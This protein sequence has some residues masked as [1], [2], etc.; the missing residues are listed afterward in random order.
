MNNMTSKSTP[1]LIAALVIAAFLV[2]TLWTKVQYLEK[3]PA[4]SAS[5]SPEANPT[6]PDQTPAAKPQINIRPEDPTKGSK[7]AKLTIT[8]FSDPSCPFCA[9]AAG[10]SATVD[11]LK[12]NDP[13]WT[14]PVPGIIKEYVNTGKV[15]L[16]FKYY[17]GHGTGEEAMKYL[18]CA[19]DQ[20]KFWELHDEEF[21][22]QEKLDKASLDGYVKKLGLDSA[23]IA[24]CLS[25][26]KYDGFAAK[27]TEDGKL[28]QVSGTPGFFIGDKS[29]PGAYS[30]ATLKVAIE[31]ELKK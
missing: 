24:E 21:A 28:A 8:V 29:F 30:F 12:K 17:P 4:P 16:V 11:Y 14:A 26:G 22:N 31:E 7:D 5:P 20:G 6:T 9:A 15:R 25:S 13:T 27:E 10:Y 3:K 18:W 23:K 1:I 19:N 2:G